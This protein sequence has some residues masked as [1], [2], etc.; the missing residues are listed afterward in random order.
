MQCE[1][2]SPTTLEA[3]IELPSSLIVTNLPMELFSSDQLKEE[4]EQLFKNTDE[5]AS[6]HY[7]STFRRC[8]VQFRGADRATAARIH[9]DFTRF[10]GK[11]LRC[12]FSQVFTPK[13]DDD[14]HFLKLPQLEKQFL[15]SP[16]ASPP[17]GWEQS[18]EAQPS[19]NFE[20]LSRLAALAR[21]EST[22]EVVPAGENCPSIKIF[23]CPDDDDVPAKPKIV[24]TSRPPT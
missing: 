4:F 14:E 10:H 13:P 23:P 15:I 18:K 3:E 20:L 1:L 22:I 12:F 6:F 7:L 17:V 5:T 21:E 11:V 16:P 24:H 8:R 19:F 2:T 9:L